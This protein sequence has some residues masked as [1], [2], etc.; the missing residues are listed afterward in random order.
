M[1][2]PGEH[3]AFELT[4]TTDGTPFKPSLPLK[5]TFDKVASQRLGTGGLQRD[6]LVVQ[7]VSQDTRAKTVTGELRN[8]GTILYA[9]AEVCVVLRDIEGG[10]VGVG[11]R[12]ELESPHGPFS[13][14][15]P[16]DVRQLTWQFREMPPGTFE[17]LAMGIDIS[18]NPPC[19]RP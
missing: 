2:F 4:V 6:G 10:V 7:L 5:A 12:H 19:C 14:F 9:I 18:A 17:F 1:L 8:E 16:G 13:S 11:K 3:G 15:A